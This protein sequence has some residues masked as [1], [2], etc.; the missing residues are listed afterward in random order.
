[1]TPNS[2]LIEAFW[3]A[4]LNTLDVVARPTAYESWSFGDNAQMANELGALVKTGI[5]A[6]TASLVWEYEHEDKP[7][8]QVGGYS[9]IEDGAGAPI[10]IIQTT[11]VTVK[12]FH[13]VDAR[14]AYDEGEGDRSL[15][16]WRH[17]HWQFFTRACEAISRIPRDDMPIVCERFRVIYGLET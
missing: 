5:K 14:F 3:Q 2:E 15:A 13:Q 11:E 4:F 9:V 16:Y 7:L 1:M 12:P 8:P 10:C 6:A 17:A